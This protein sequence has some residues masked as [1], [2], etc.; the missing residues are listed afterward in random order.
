[1]LVL[2]NEAEHKIDQHLQDSLRSLTGERLGFLS[3]W[4]QLPPDLVCFVHHHEQV[5]EV[6]V[7]A[8]TQSRDTI[9]YLELNPF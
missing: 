6:E 4:L 8:L 3:T 2:L 1:M 9:H 5:P 7:V